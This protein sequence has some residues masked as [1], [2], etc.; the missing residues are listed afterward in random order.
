MVA[1]PG[2]AS[3]RTGAALAARRSPV[4]GEPIAASAQPVDGR[5]GG[6][7]ATVHWGPGARSRSGASDEDCGDHAAAGALGKRVGRSRSER[8][9]VHPGAAAGAATTGP[10]LTVLHR[11]FTSPAGPGFVQIAD[12]N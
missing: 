11:M 9:G 10:V 4:S 2:Q 6:H 1:G 7:D 3:P 8:V 5:R 12:R